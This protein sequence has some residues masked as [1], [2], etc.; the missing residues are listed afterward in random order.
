MDASSPL[1]GMTTPQL[2]AALASAQAAYVALMSGQRTVNLSY[3]Q[4]DG[5]KSVT[6]DKVEG[7]IAQLRFF[8]QELQR[9]LGNLRCR[10]RRFASFSWGWR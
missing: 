10:P 6:Y 8:I 1:Y 9:A 4:G 5:S 7:G 2:Q 3:A